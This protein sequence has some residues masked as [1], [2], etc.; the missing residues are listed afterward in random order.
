MAG[1]VVLVLAIGWTV[2]KHIKQRYSFD[3]YYIIFYGLLCSL[4]GSCFLLSK[5]LGKRAPVDFICQGLLN[6]PHCSAQ[7]LATTSASLA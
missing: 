1:I 6:Y 3:H 4:L 5:Q 7:R 2:R